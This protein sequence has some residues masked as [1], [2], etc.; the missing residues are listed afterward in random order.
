MRIEKPR[1]A[2]FLIIVILFL[3][4]VFFRMFSLNS[5]YDNLCKVKYGDDWKS[6]YNNDF[7]RFC[8][9][10]NYSEFEVDDYARYPDRDERK[11]ICNIPNFFSFKGG[12]LCS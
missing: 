4:F 5:N 7:G 10:L 2:I 12:N 1:V 9:H 6:N 8:I 3:C 11:E